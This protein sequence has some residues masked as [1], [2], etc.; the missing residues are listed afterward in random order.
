ML[1]KCTLMFHS[2]L[3]FFSPRERETPGLPLSCLF[4][5]PRT[6]YR[7]LF[8]RTSNGFSFITFGLLGFFTPATWPLWAPLLFDLR[9][10]I[11]LEFSR[12]DEQNEQLL[13]CSS[14]LLKFTIETLTSCPPYLICLEIVDSPLTVPT[15]LV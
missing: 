8:I 7:R 4:F 15:L 10:G 12:P 6:S 9:F 2:L 14:H 13:L 3:T 11:V 1:K 5:L